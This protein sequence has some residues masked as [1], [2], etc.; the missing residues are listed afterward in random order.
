M[1]LVCTAALAWFTGLALGLTP[2][3]Q[4]ATSG[5]GRI[6]TE[7]RSVSDFEAISLAGSMDIVVRQGAREGVE[8]QADDKLLPLIET[9]V[10]PGAAGRTLQIRFKRGERIYN[11]GRVRVIVDVIKLGAVATSGSGDVLVEGLKTPAFKL[12]ISGSSDARLNG[13]VTDTLDVRISGSGD[14]VASGTA[15]QVSLG[16]AGSGDA[17]LAGLIA[18]EVQVRIA[19]SGDANV[20]ANKSLDVSVAGSGDVRYGGSVAA[21]K[22]SM[23][24]SGTL[25]RR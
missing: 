4:A 1:K 12:T 9:V 23:A 6:A 11:Q 19:G 21:I 16:I 22:S 14:V 8:V 18:D 13:L 20:T 2:A 5:S 17:N 15:R 3:A 7:Q 10:E 25:S 24:G